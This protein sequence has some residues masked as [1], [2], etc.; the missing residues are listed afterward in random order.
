MSKHTPEPWVYVPGRGG[1]TVE[2]SH[3]AQIAVISG[4]APLRGDQSIPFEQI[5]WANGRLIA[6]SPKMLA[7]LKGIL[8]A[9][10]QPATYPADL[11][12]VRQIA[13]AA[14]AKVESES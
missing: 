14:I 1:G 7:A 4:Q 3:G 8:A 5:Q 10:T 12:Y 2:D 6:V 11:E 9:L 13:S